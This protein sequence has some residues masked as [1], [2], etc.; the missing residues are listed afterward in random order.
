LPG[1][2]GK[3]I[4]ASQ[5]LSGDLAQLVPLAQSRFG[6]VAVRNSSARSST[7]CKAA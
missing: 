2:L 6:V 3:G 4:I 5:L 7:A 1:D